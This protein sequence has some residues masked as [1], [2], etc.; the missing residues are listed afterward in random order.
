[1]IAADQR[2][3]ARFTIVPSPLP[4]R[5]ALIAVPRSSM[6]RRNQQLQRALQTPWKARC[7]AFR[8]RPLAAEPTPGFR[9]RRPQLPGPRA[10]PGP[11]VA[12]YRQLWTL[13]THRND[14]AMW[15]VTLPE[16]L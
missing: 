2:P 1:M 16:T 3:S 6:G 7:Y 13:A 9:R 12:R 4:R 15:W 10:K 5:P 11:C 8:A 14:G